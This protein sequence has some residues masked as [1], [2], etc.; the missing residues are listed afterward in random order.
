MPSDSREAG[1]EQ[2]HNSISP[3]ATESTS[4]PHLKPSSIRA[5][6]RHT[7][8]EPFLHN[9]MTPEADRDLLACAEA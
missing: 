1:N 6:A 2:N 8:P 5:P 3:N 4:A 9:E 7:T